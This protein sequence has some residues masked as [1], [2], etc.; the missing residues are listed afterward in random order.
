MDKV[1]EFLLEELESSYDL[2]H[3]IRMNNLL[4]AIDEFIETAYEEVKEDILE[5]GEY[6]ETSKYL[7]ILNELNKYKYPDH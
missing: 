4:E 1:R 5:T 2:D 6:I 7:E 3:T